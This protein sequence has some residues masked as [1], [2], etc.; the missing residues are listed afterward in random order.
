MS[1]YEVDVSL[2]NAT[3]GHRFSD[4]SEPLDKDSWYWRTAEPLL[5][6]G[7]PNMGAIYRYARSEYG[8]CT[9]RVYVDTETGAKAI[10]WVFVSRQKYDDYGTTETYIREAWVTVSRLVEPARPAVY[11]YAGVAA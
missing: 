6:H 7:K 5:V 9:G 2:V 8:R 4:F 3:E 11:E 10:G 1:A